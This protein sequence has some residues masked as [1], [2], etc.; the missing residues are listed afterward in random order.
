MN[1]YDEPEK[2]VILNKLP[3]SQTAEDYRKQL[4][5]VY[6]PDDQIAS[7]RFAVTSTT[8]LSIKHIVSNLNQLPQA[9]YSTFSI[10]YNSNENSSTKSESNWHPVN[11]RKQY[12][13]ILN[14]KNYYQNNMFLKPRRFRTINDLILP[15]KPV[16]AAKDDVRQHRSTATEEN[17][18]IDSGVVL[19]LGRRVKI[20]GTYRRKK[21]YFDE[22]NPMKGQ[23]LEHYAYDMYS[24]FKPPLP[25]DVNNLATNQIKTTPYSE[26]RPRPITKPLYTPL[27]S[28]YFTDIETRP[29]YHRA[30]TPNVNLVNFD[31][32]SHNVPFDNN[33]GKLYSFS[34]E[35]HPLTIE[36]SIVREHV[37]SPYK[38]PNFP[39][40]NQ[41]MQIAA[42]TPIVR[43]QQNDINNNRFNHPNYF[44]YRSSTKQSNEFLNNDKL[45]SQIIVYL[46]LYPTMKKTLP[47][48]VDMLKSESTHILA[49]NPIPSNLVVNGIVSPVSVNA[50]NDLFDLSEPDNDHHFHED[51]SIS[52]DLEADPSNNIEIKEVYVDPTK[53]TDDDIS[54]VDDIAVITSAAPTTTLSM[55]SLSPAHNLQP[56]TTKTPFLPT[57]VNDIN[58]SVTTEKQ[59][60]IVK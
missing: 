37:Y 11:H 57:P 47:R 41:N 53:Q 23:K 4:T 52:F 38:R 30:V 22:Y 1:D 2:L 10:P 7:N 15:A 40:I 24:K 29:N 44:P 49:E 55:S 25:D 8:P 28:H 51:N 5:T 59:S 42:T 50:L 20:E 35:P 19:P 12:R 16:L 39:V 60:E 9:M 14:A 27:P 43:Y 56:S 54:T 3:T 18:R 36:E 13:N 21:N 17:D 31:M 45:L 26:H 33:S 46:N 48:N 32:T 34:L 58:E 6:Y